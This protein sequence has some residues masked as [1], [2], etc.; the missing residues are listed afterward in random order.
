MNNLL[1]AP[2]ALPLAAAITLIPARTRPRLSRGIAIAANLAGLAAALA[3][4]A[5]TYAGGPA[6]LAFGKWSPPYAITFTVD[7]FGALM[8]LVTMVVSTATLVFACYSLDADRERYFFYPFFQFLIMGVN[9]A[10][11]TGD[12]F[13]LF[14]WFEVLLVSSYAM[15]ALGSERYQLQE[16]FKYLVINAVGSA[17]FLLAIALLYSLTHTLNMADAACRLADPELP[18]GLVAATAVLFV[19]VFG[20]KGALFPLYMWLPRSYFAP[21]TVVS[22]LF[23]GLLT[24]VGVYALFRVVPLMFGN[25][26]PELWPILVVVSGLTMFF[27]VIGAL[28]QWDMKR[29]LSYHII[30]QIGYMIM[31]LG[32]RAEAA[33]AGGIFYIVH[34][35]L[36]K[37]ALFLVA[38]TVEKLRGSTHLRSLGGLVETAPAVSTLFLVAGLSLA[39]APPLSGFVAKFMLIRAGVQQGAYTI[40]T[41]SLLVSFLTLFSMMKIF[42]YGFWRPPEAPDRLSRGATVRIAATAS[43]VLAGVALGIGAAAALPL[44]NEAARQLLDRGHYIEAVLQECPWSSRY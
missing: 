42:R 43:L 10:F 30:S 37:T 7:L 28:A 25:V 36:V 24:K 26:V 5:R 16:T 4:V 3:I 20:L 19:I 13:N 27:G 17:L 40:V 44:A 12:M 38:G 6:V 35:I 23:G 1:V 11:L 32:L 2:V 14:V 31:G 18:R 22:A 33:V 21:P 15:M 8:V 34:H 9:G 29:I 41:V 39:G